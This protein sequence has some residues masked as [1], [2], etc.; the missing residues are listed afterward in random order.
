MEYGLPK[1]ERPAE[2]NDATEHVNALGQFARDLAA[3]LH[4]FAWR[5]CAYRN[6]DDYHKNYQTSLVALEKIN[7][8]TGES[9]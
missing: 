8:R 4:G 7:R 6:T 9:D 5:M 2:P 1:L 3:W